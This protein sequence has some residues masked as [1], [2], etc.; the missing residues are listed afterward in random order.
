M[1]CTLAEKLIPLF[2]SNDLPDDQMKTL[3]AHL[4]CCA[5][6]RQLAAEFSESQNWLRIFA[7]PA[8]D[9]AIFDDLRAGLAREMA[10]NEPR[11]RWFAPRWNPRFAFAAAMAAI[12][13]TAAF[14][15][16]V[17]RHQPSLEDKL[18]IHPEKAP[19]KNDLPRRPV[20]YGERKRPV[21]RQDNL[22]ARSRSLT[23]PILQQPPVSQEPRDV[24][25][26]DTTKNQEML[27]I[28][29]QTADP[30]IRIIWFAPKADASS[31]NGT[32]I[33]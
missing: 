22:S 26:T 8:F 4:D 21:A 31:S 9:E 24:A 14:G 17:F 2:V 10:G 3:C 27:R 30:N 11:P 18:T 15:I 29:M 20:R 19:Q 13:L 6:C 16:Y 7:A 12:L 25:A 23:L 28:E 1:Q 5:T 32:N 33:K